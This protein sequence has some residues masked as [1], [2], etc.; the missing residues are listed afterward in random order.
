MSSQDSMSG[1]ARDKVCNSSSS[2]SSSSS[3]SS[4]SDSSSY[5]SDSYEY[6]DS[7]S[8]VER[9]G[10]LQSPCRSTTFSCTS[11]SGIAQKSAYPRSLPDFQ[12]TG[13]SLSS[14][15]DFLLTYSFICSVAAT[16]AQT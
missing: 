14:N 9:S 6:S 2:S 3:V 7:Y 16:C 10:C 13:P 11:P 15:F 4:S 12:Y 8:S 1:G 5:E